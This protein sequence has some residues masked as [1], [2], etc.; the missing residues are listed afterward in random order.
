MLARSSDLE[1][2]AWQ[3]SAHNSTLLTGSSG[4]PGMADGQHGRALGAALR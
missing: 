4:S 2:P 1:S 3:I